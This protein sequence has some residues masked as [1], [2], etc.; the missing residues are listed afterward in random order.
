MEYTELA[1]LMLKKHHPTRHVTASD[2]MPQHGG[3]E[4]LL[5]S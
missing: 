4:C 2:P 5:E 1:W 3:E